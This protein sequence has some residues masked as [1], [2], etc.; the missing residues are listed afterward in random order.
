[1]DKYHGTID[2]VQQDGTDSDYFGPNAPSALRK[3]SIYKSSQID[4]TVTFPYFSAH[5]HHFELL[6]SG[7]DSQEVSRHKFKVGGL[8][9]LSVQAPRNAIFEQGTHSVD[10]SGF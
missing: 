2:R 6:T 3:W 10:G 4:L 5:D 8:D 7:R 9:P 1:M